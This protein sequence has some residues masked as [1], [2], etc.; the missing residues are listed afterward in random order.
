MW[1]A[2]CRNKYLSWWAP[3]WSMGSPPVG[4]YRKDGKVKAQG[5]FIKDF[6][7]CFSNIYIYIPYQSI[8]APTSYWHNSFPTHISLSFSLS[9][10]CS[11]HPA[12][13]SEG[14]SWRKLTS[15]WASVTHFVR[16][17]PTSADTTGHF[18]EAIQKCH[19]KS[20]AKWTT[21]KVI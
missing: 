2:N 4:L 5:K 15:C 1:L 12:T 20:L 6:H 10:A 21:V 9:H 14:L 17:W 3:M 8:T 11:P 19:S 16:P 7:E 13:G 18:N